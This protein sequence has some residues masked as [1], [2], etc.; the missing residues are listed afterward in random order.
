VRILGV[1]PGSLVTG[2][3]VLESVAGRCTLVDSDVI[4]IDH[5]LPLADGLALLH[6]RLVRVVDDVRPASAAVEAPFHGA[7][8][9]S[10][11]KLAHARG[12]VLAALGA[13]GV[14][15][16][17]YTPATVKKSVTGDGRADKEQVRRMV[18]HLLGRVRLGRTRDLS[19]ALAVALCHAAVAPRL[20]ALERAGVP[21]SGFVPR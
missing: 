12:V 3:G 4:R 15:V 5:E 13:A 10:A 11:L 9:R 1:D 17:E 14:P 8:A 21:R 6:A 19:D 18:S 20:A 7:N 16:A 2:W